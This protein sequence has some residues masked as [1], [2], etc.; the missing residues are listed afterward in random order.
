LKSRGLGEGVKKNN[1]IIFGKGVNA[2]LPL[3]SQTANKRT[4]CSRSG[5]K[6]FKI[7]NFFS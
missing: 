3:H 4:E 5:I 6:F 2:V 1:K 7:N